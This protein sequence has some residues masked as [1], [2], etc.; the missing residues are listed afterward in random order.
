M[1]TTT[2]VVTI[3]DDR[4]DWTSD[5]V[6]QALAAETGGRFIIDAR[7]VHAHGVPTTPEQFGDWLAHEL[8]HSGATVD[9]EGVMWGGALIEFPEIAGEPDCWIWGI[10]IK[11]TQRGDK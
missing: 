8:R 11:L 7:Q 2:F 6:H 4:K 1:T 9:T 3:D 10:T 5:D